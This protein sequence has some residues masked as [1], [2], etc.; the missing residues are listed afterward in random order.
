MGKGWVQGSSEAWE[1]QSLLK[2]Q[3]DL[4]RC[5]PTGMKEVGVKGRK[6]GVGNLGGNQHGRR[7][8]KRRVS[9]DVHAT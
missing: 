1:A 4:V 5:P 2:G 9:A 7:L 3:T 6:E 8:V